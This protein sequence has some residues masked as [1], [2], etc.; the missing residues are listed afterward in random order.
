MDRY[1]ALPHTRDEKEKLKC[2]VHPVPG[3]LE[4]DK[5]LDVLVNKIAESQDITKITLIINHNAGLV[6]YI[7][8]GDVLMEMRPVGCFRCPPPGAAVH[9]R[10]GSPFQVSRSVG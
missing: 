9:T 4:D 7:K 6:F 8:W 5:Q 3:K 1:M 10:P 2:G